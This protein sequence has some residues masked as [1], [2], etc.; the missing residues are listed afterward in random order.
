MMI[1]EITNANLYLLLPGKV[2]DVAM[3]VAQHDKIPALEALRH[4]YAS[5]T[6]K[7]MEKEETKIWHMGP[8]ALFQDYL[9]N[10]NREK[11]C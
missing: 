1:P 6:Y 8:V 3:R 5:N 7:Q 11:C 10:Q 4:F 9:E 2:A